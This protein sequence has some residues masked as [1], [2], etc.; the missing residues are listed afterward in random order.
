M[1]AFESTSESHRRISPS[2]KHFGLVDAFS[3]QLSADMES[4]TDDVIRAMDGVAAVSGKWLLQ[5]QC[6]EM[7]LRM[8]E[9]NWKGDPRHYLDDHLRS[10]DCAHARSH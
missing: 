9:S 4:L 8:A 5:L 2:G 7:P 1:N 10:G 6:R 3:Y